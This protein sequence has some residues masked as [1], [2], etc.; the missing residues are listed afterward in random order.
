MLSSHL[1]ETSTHFWYHIPTQRHRNPFWD[2][3]FNEKKASF[4]LVSFEDSVLSFG[5]SDALSLRASFSDQSDYEFL[6]LIEKGF[7]PD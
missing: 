7:Q 4:H 6:L 3:I 2:G 1:K 5:S